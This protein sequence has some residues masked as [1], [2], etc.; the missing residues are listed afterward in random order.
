[1]AV[2]PSHSPFTSRELIFGDFA[3]V[4]LWW[5]AATLLAA[6]VIWSVLPA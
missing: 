6:L 1:M 4:G 2:R 3:A 5:V